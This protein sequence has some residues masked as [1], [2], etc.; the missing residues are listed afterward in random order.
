VVVQR[1]KRVFKV[2][3]GFTLLGAG[4]LMIVAPGPGLLTIALGLAMLATEF[5][6]A[7]RWLDSIKSGATRLR[8]AVLPSSKTKPI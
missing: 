2:I 1:T 4:L 6:W 5:K 3:G 7:Q 8:D